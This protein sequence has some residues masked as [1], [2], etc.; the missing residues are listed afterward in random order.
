MNNITCLLPNGQCQHTLAD[1]KHDCTTQYNGKQDTEVAVI[2]DSSI[3]LDF[4]IYPNFCK[5]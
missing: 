5:R 3:Y 1:C 2:F 4:L